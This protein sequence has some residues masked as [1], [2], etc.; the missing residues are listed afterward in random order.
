MKAGPG[1]FE[2][3]GSRPEN[4]KVVGTLAKHGFLIHDGFLYNGSLPGSPGRGVYTQ[5]NYPSMTDHNALAVTEGLSFGWG[6]SHGAAANF[7]WV[8]ITGLANGKYRLDPG[9]NISVRF[10]ESDTTNN[11]AG[12]SSGSGRAE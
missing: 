9:A 1:P 6:D 2:A 4:G 12:R 5:G 7:Q 11:T 8:D 3:N 10:S